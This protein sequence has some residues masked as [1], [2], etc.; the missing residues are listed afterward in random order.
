MRRLLEL[1]APAKNLAIGIE[2][3]NHGADAVYIGGPAFGARSQADNPIEDVAQL[4]RYAHRFGA[5]IYVTLNTIL[6]DEELTQAR[7]VIWQCYHAGVDAIIIQ[8][9]GILTLDLPPIALHASTQMDNRTPEKVKFLADVGFTQVVLARELSLPQ[10]QA[11]HAQTDVPLEFFIHGAICVSYSGQCYISYAHTGRSANRGECS[12]A[13]RLPYSLTDHDGTLIAK[14]KHLLSVKD[15]NQSANLKALI[16]AGVSSFK[17]E[18]RLK[19]MAYVKNITAYYRQEL[20]KLLTIMPDYARA[21][22]G[23]SEFL[24]TPNPDKTFNRGATDYFV[25]GRNTEIGA[26]DSPKFVGEKIG[27]LTAI[28]SQTLTLETKAVLNNGDG[29]C[30]Y[31][32]RG[33]LLG[34]RVNRA[35]G[36]QV[37]LAEA[38]PWLQPGMT[39]YRNHDQAF[40]RILEKPSAVRRLAVDLSLSDTP[41]GLCLAVVDESGVLAQATVT[42]VKA[43]AEQPARAEAQIRVQLSKLGNTLFIAREIQIN[44]P[45]LWFIP[46]ALLNGLR[47]DV[48]DV[49]LQAR[50]AAYRRPSVGERKTPAPVYP[51]SALSYLSNVLNQGAKTFYQAHGVTLIEAAFEANEQREEVPVMITKHC[52]RFSFQLCPKQVKGT[53]PDPMVLTQGK[54]RLRLTFDCKRCEMHVHGRLKSAVIQATRAPLTFMPR[55]P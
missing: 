47:R 23:K 29:L 34:V 43:P 22:A 51:E 24:F 15:N 27:L 5:R 48:I 7:D 25:T 30:A 16:E 2:A 39:L 1:L 19:D 6:N 13:C 12:Q 9:M 41:D 37:V 35:Q 45:T 17:I 46:T 36:Q 49:L 32:T 3:I 26:F 52:L 14:Q 42:C 38:A 31:T 33:E 21:S 4:C 50:E 54:E 20:D 11:I 18:G 10:I 55:R 40:T 28:E 44:L 53:R 8:D